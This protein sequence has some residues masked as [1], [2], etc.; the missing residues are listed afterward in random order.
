MGSPWFPSNFTYKEFTPDTYNVT[1]DL[2]VSTGSWSVDV[3]TRTMKYIDLGN[4]NFAPG[5]SEVGWIHTNVSLHDLVPIA[6]IGMGDAVFEVIGELV[7]DLEGFG[8]IEVWVLEDI[9]FPNA[10][11]WYEKST[12]I[13]LNGSFIG[14]AVNYTFAFLDTNA[15]FEYY[16][17][18]GGGGGIPGYNIIFFVTV[19]GVFSLIVAFRK[20]KR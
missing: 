2:F 17:P 1:W 3:S 8:K 16:T 7:Y 13:M 14:P 4:P 5:I 20:R 6:V 15:H 18:P 10:I 12:G 11:V 19:I 9:V